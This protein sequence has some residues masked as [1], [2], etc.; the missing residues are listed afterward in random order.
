MFGLSELEVIL[1]ENKKGV[2]IDS[3]EYSKIITMLKNISS[4]YDLDIPEHWLL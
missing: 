3:G 1:D 2:S 4:I